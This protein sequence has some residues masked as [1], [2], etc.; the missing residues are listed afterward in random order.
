MWRGSVKV[1]CALNALPHA[2]EGLFTDGSRFAANHIAQ[3]AQF[4]D[5]TIAAGIAGMNTMISQLSSLVQRV[6]KKNPKL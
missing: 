5:A 4:K 2:D 1:Y 3:I 6:G